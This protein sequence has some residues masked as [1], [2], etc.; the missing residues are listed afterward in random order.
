MSKVH[1]ESLNIAFL[2]SWQTNTIKSL[3]YNMI[4]NK[5]TL[6]VVFTYKDGAKSLLLNA[7]SLKH[8][9]RGAYQTLGTCFNPCHAS[10]SLYTKFCFQGC[11]NPRGCKPKGFTQPMVTNVV[12]IWLVLCQQVSVQ[13]PLLMQF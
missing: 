3:K 4:S 12:G 5:P 1:S 9:S 13:I 11:V 2:S 8:A 10:L 6:C 7:T